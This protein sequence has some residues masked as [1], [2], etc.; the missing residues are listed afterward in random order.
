MS[1][2]QKFLALLLLSFLGTQRPMS[3]QE[4]TARL[5][6]GRTLTSAILNEE[7]TVFV[8]LPTSYDTSKA[9]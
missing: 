4:V 1:H 2:A 8:H 7:R 9:S 3:A 6:V 5:G